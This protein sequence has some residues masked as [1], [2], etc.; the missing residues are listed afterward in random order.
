MAT[1]WAFSNNIGK[2]NRKDKELDL[3]TGHTFA[4]MEK[5]KKQYI[6]FFTQ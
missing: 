3:L 4:C 5:M 1:F 6:F 2:R